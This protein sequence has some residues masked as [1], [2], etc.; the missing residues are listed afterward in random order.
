ML[1]GMLDE[2]VKIITSNGIRIIGEVTDY[3]TDGDN[4]G[5]GE[6]IIV[7]IDGIDEDIELYEKDIASIEALR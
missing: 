4:K 6:S 2:K 7:L 3:F 1:S 5:E